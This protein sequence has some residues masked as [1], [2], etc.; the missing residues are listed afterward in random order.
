VW[1]SSGVALGSIDVS[2]TRRPPRCALAVFEKSSA[3][4]HLFRMEAPCTLRRQVP[5]PRSCWTGTVTDDD[6]GARFDDAQRAPP[7]CGAAGTRAPIQWIAALVAYVRRNVL[8]TSM[9]GD[10]SAIGHVGQ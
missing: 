6:P 7:R 8:P 1:A 9:Q 2:G 5:R 10:R 3:S 4:A